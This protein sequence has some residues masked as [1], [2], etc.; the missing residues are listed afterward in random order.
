VARRRLAAALAEYIRDPNRPEGFY[1]FCDIGG[2]TIDGSIF[3]L[4]R[5]SGLPRLAILSASVAPYGTA[6]VARA[7]VRKLDGTIDRTAE[8]EIATP[9]AMRRGLRTVGVRETKSKS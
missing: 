3:R 7:M 8:I 2:G 9:K 1:G 5:N 4:H 6:A